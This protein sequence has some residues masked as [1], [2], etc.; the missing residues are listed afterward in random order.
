M[1]EQNDEAQSYALMVLAGLVALVIGGVLALAP[2]P[3]AK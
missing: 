2:Q 3:T 1:S